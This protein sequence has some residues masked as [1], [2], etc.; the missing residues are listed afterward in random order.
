MVVR[1][2]PMPLERLMAT[3]SVRPV[4]RESSA[5]V[6][7]R[8]LR[9]VMVTIHDSLLLLR[10]KGLRREEVLDVAAAYHTAVKVRVSRERFERAQA[11]KAKRK[12]GG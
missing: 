3:K 11:R 5:F 9:P 4:T 6:R 12:G 1:V 7:E 8:G 2:Q 10:P